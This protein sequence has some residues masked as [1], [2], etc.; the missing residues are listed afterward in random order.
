MDDG[1]DALQRAPDRLVIPDVT[2]LE[3]DLAAEIVGS[4]PVRMNL[5]VE[6]SSARTWWPSASSRSAR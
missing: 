4:L 3:L 6:L 5:P 2:D 1:V